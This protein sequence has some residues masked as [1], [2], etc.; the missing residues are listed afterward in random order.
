MKV[1][2]LFCLLSIVS[3]SS[4]PSATAQ[5]PPLPP[6]AHA[7]QLLRELEQ[8]EQD[9]K[10]SLNQAK[11]I[12]YQELL[13]GASSGSQAAQI[14]RKAIG[15]IEFDGLAGNARRYEEWKKKNEEA[16]RSRDMQDALSLTIR[17]MLLSLER[18]DSGEGT[19]F[20]QPSLDHV[21]ELTELYSSM[22]SG[23]P[24]EDPARKILNE[25][26][27]ANAFS[28]WLGLAP[29]FP[30]N[31]KG[32]SAP[33]ATTNW[34]TRPGSIA[35]I[36]SKNVR[37]LLRQ[38]KDPRL[39]ETWDMEIQV[40][41][42]A[43]EDMDKKFDEVRVRE[44][45]IPKLLFAKAKDAIV[46]GQ[47]DAAVGLLFGILRE[48]PHHPDFPSWVETTRGILQPAAVEPVEEPAPQPP[49]GQ[50]VINP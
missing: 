26:I 7:T 32:D 49:A 40:Q 25:S 29:Y 23:S 36:L 18:A 11:R 2:L 42:E 3:V 27:E 48:F 35:G 6:P 9:Q 20:V 44:V 1:P 39:L 38:Y 10:N 24:G 16:M 15:S 37:P 34:E 13:P 50:A 14:Y 8:I 28:K 45:E 47:S 12:A 31:A 41:Q 43:L 4:L 30:K 33:S 17:Y 19:R 22:G 46:L 5:D 21:R